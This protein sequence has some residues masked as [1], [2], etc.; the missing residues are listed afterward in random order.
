MRDRKYNGGERTKGEEG[1][2]AVHGSTERTLKVDDEREK[3]I[4]RPRKS[5]TMQHKYVYS[6]YIQNT[7]P[8]NRIQAQRQ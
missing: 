1:G 8:R 4:K 3:K 2:H 7:K 6:I 5:H